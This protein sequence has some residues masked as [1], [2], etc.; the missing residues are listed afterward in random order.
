MAVHSAATG[1]PF[2]L[3]A[4]SRDSRPTRHAA[5]HTLLEGVALLC[6]AVVKRRRPRLSWGGRG[7]STHCPAR[8]PPTAAPTLPRRRGDPAEAT[9][10]R[11]ARVRRVVV[12]M[13]AR[14]R[15]TKD[16]SSQVPL[17]SRDTSTRSDAPRRRGG[18]RLRG[19]VGRHRTTF[20]HARI[21]GVRRRAVWFALPLVRDVSFAPAGRRRFVRESLTKK[22]CD[23]VY[24]WGEPTGKNP[25]PSQTLPVM[26]RTMV[27]G[28]T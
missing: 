23:C 13:R 26:L 1:G 14:E 25:R 12:E 24:P 22:A 19:Q 17:R 7:D 3:A 28:S 21:C 4:V 6:I 11:L 10:M 5:V 8:Q 20:A 18:I 27:L 2:A 9:D 16:G 15:C